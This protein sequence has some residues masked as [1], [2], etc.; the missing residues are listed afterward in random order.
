MENADHLKGIIEKAEVLCKSEYEIALAQLIS[1]LDDPDA[2]AAY[3][4]I[5]GI[6]LKEPF[7][8]RVPRDIPSASGWLRK[9]RQKS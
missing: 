7:S 4:R 5:L 6:I 8:F 1:A 3:G 9:S 2:R